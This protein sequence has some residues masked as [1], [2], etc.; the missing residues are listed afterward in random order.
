MCTK[1]FIILQLDQ[2]TQLCNNIKKKYPG[3]EVDIVLLEAV[4]L[5]RQN[6]IIEAI[7][8]LKKYEYEDDQRSSDANLHCSL[9][10]VK[11][12]LIQV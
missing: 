5:S 3:L 10:A 7:D 9:V 8:L 1:L 6:K 4:M 12:L 11:L 2:F